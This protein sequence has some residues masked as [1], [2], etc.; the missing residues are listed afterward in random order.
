MT[1]IYVPKSVLSDKQ[2]CFPSEYYS[3]FIET[4]WIS[5][6]REPDFLAIEGGRDGLSS[7]WWRFI[8]GIV[9]AILDILLSVFKLNW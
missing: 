6:F 3:L 9:Y 4:I 2:K 5:Q 1:R 7:F 8:D